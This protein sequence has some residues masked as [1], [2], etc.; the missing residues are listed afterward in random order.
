MFLYYMTMLMH[1]PP[2]Y[3]MRHKEICRFITEKLLHSAT[4][5]LEVYME[6]LISLILQKHIA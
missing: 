2:S 5:E 4:S 6:H 3:C 1:A